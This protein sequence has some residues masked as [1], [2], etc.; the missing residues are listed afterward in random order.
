MLCEFLG[1]HS[2]YDFFLNCD[3]LWIRRYTPNVSKKKLSLSSALKMETF[4]TQNKIIDKF[5]I[6]LSYMLIDT[7]T[8]LVH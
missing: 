6:C 8:V 4:E 2:G 1:F 7:S 5:N 3:A